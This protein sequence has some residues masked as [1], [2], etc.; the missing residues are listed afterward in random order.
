MELL[1]AKNA[2][3]GQPSILVLQ[4]GLDENCTSVQV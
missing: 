1:D 2:N 3:L 4:D